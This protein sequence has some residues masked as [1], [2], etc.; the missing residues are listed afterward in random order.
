MTILDTSILSAAF[1]RRRVGVPEP[2][3]VERLRRMIQ[4][5]E[6]V[7]IP[8]IALQEILSGVR[9][10]AESERLLGLVEGFPLLL[11]LRVH[12]LEAARIANACRRAGIATSATDCL[13]AAQ[14][15][16]ER[17]RLFTLDQDFARMAPH[18]GLQLVPIGTQP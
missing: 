6:P 15:I 17:G 5:D 9:T 2:P 18:C 3:E 11:A 7:A 13:I 1:R 16:A 14:T 4:E 8:G 10:D 12:H